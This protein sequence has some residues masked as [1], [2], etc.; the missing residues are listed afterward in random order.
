MGLKIIDIKINNSLERKYK[1][2]CS[3]RMEAQGQANTKGLSGTL[4]NIF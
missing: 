1:G 2:M 4:L 3:S